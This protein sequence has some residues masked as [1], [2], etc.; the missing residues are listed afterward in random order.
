[1]MTFDA[2][3]NIYSSLFTC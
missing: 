2:P 1:M 3:V